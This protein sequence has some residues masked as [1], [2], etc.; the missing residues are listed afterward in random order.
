MLED[1][2][3]SPRFVIFA[4][5][6]LGLSACTPTPETLF[7]EGEQAFRANDY[8]TAWIQIE[9]GLKQQPGNSEMK[10]LLL[11]TFLKLGEGER[12][13]ML[14]QALPADLRTTA[15]VRLLQGEADILRGKFDAALASLAEID[16]AEADRLAA[17]A[18]IG[19]GDIAQAAA[20]FEAGLKRKEPSAPLLASYA[21]F[22][23]ERGE[24]NRADDLVSQSLRHDPR[25]IDGMLLRA[26]L[27][28]RRNQMPESLAAF[29][30]V[31]KLHAD[32][33]NARLGEAR[34]MAAMGLRDDALALAKALQDEAPKSA[35]VAGVRAEVAAQAKDWKSVRS[36]LQVFEKEMIKHPK[37]AVLY[38][39]ALIELGLPAQAV[40]YLA[41]QYERQPG[42]RK[43]R[44]LY[45]RALNDSGEKK[46][47]LAVL[48]PLADRPDA[49]PDELRL[50]TAIAKGAGDPVAARLEQRI[51]KTAPE[52][53]GGQIAVADKALRN[54]QWAQAERAYLAI[55]KELGPSNGMVLNNLAYA[56]D[57]LGKSQHALKNALAA[58]KLE[59][60]N[61]AILDTAGVLLVANGERERGIVMLR[62]AAGI[63]PA[64]AAIKRHLAEAEAT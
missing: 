9:Q 6:A 8:N 51:D 35:A 47:A 27:H 62:K 54:S 3:T 46:L 21:R 56:Q 39:E 14:L 60:A 20:R 61:A 32:N 43:L 4:S 49:A 7:A 22:A 41:P 11:S 2:M 24:W 23:F 25:L 55:V 52:W 42:W 12:A 31:R 36:T 33:F 26:E 64:N 45:S 34:V 50:A 29:R 10:M 13:N 19:K 59:P 48:Q 53:V 16:S 63:A 58:V 15:R 40:T 37:A 30:A 5:L 44:V 38:A 17:L 28:E 57:K 1:M 18:Y